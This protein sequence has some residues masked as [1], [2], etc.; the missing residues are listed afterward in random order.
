MIIP[1]AEASLLDATTGRK[2]AVFVEF[3]RDTAPMD[4]VQLYNRFY[5]GRD[6]RGAEWAQGPDAMF[7]EVMIV[8]ISRTRAK[9]IEGLVARENRNGIRFRVKLLEVIRGESARLTG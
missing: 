7:P 9:C 8:T 6:Y 5:E 1:D 2:R 4:K 3:D